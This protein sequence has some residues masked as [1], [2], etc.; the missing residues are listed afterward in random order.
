MR[1]PSQRT[2]LISLSPGLEGTKPGLIPS[3]LPSSSCPASSMVKAAPRMLDG[4]VSVPR[5]GGSDPA[6][7]PS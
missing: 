2:N 3:L 5:L 4:P 7:S 1:V 6:L